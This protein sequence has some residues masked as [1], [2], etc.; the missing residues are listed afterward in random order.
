MVNK[1]DCFVVAEKGR[2]GEAPR[3]RKRGNLIAKSL[4]LKAVHYTPIHGSA[5]W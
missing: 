1:A 4:L 2:E 5:H 3:G